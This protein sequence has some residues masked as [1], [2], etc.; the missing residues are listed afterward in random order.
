MSNKVVFYISFIHNFTL[1]KK[2]SPFIKSFG[3]HNYLIYET[4]KKALSSQK[5]CHLISLKGLGKNLF[6]QS[7]LY[8]ETLVT[9]SH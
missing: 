5:P 8:L 3:K 4:F 1:N 2:M 6:L 9:D 7:D